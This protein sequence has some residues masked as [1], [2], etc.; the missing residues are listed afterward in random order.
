MGKEKRKREKEIERSVFPKSKLEVR[1]HQSGFLG[2]KIGI[3]TGMGR[4]T[5]KET[6]LL[7]GQG[8]WVDGRQTTNEDENKVRKSKEEDRQATGAGD[9]IL[10]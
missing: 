2:L 9:S 6:A 7:R 3:G 10:G 8:S 4:E 1:R 5:E